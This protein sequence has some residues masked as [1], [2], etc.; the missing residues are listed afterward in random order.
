MNNKQL[1]TEK[2]LCVNAI[3]LAE[4]KDYAIPKLNHQKTFTCH[5]ERFPIHIDIPE[6]FTIL[7]SCLSVLHGEQC[8][9]KRTFWGLN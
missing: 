2:T 4:A 9:A 7:A 3:S 1:V 8:L 5:K 6:F